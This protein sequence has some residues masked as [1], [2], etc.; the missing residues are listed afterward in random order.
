M[1]LSSISYWLSR[2]AVSVMNTRSHPPA[3]LRRPK[4]HRFPSSITLWQIAPMALRAA[5]HFGD[6][7]HHRDIERVVRRNSPRFDEDHRHSG[8]A[9][10]AIGKVTFG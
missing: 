8:V 4:L 2:S 6:P 9:A 7:A 1:L 3:W 5:D 10:F